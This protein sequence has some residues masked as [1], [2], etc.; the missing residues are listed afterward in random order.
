[1]PGQHGDG[2]VDGNAGNAGTAILS[3]PMMF[4]SVVLDVW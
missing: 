3:K 4:L 1:M 2:H